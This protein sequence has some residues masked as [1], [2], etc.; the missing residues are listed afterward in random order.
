MSDSST[1]RQLGENMH[2]EHTWSNND[3]KEEILQIFFQLTRSNSKD[4]MERL[5]DRFMT[6]I[7]KITDISNNALYNTLI[8][9]AAHTRDLE[10]GKGEYRLA[11]YLFNSFDRVGHKETAQQL[12][13]WSVTNLPVEQIQQYTNCTNT[14]SEHPLGS[15]KDIKYLWSQFEWS[16]ETSQFMIKLINNQLRKDLVLVQKG[17]PPEGL[18]GKWIPRESSQFKKMFRVLALDYFSDY[19]NTT[20]ES[21]NKRYISTQTRITAAKRK[22]YTDY[23]K[24]ISKL[25]NVLNTVQINQC[26][27]TWSNIDYDK[28]VTSIT[29]S[30]QGRAFRNKNSH[31]HCNKNPD[32]IQAASQFESWLAS[33]VSQGKTIKGTRVGINELVSQ[34]YNCDIQDHSMIS[35]INLQWEDGGK[36][37]NN[38]HNMIAMLDTSLS[39]EGAQMDAGIGLSLRVADKSCIGRRV[40]TFASTPTWHN[41]TNNQDKP[42]FVKDVKTIKNIS[43]WGTSTNFAAA[44]KLILDACVKL[45]LTNKAV[46]EL[47]LVIFSDMQI[48]YQ[49]T[50]SLTNTM[51]EHIESMYKAHGYTVLP[52]ILFWNLRS[53]NGFPVMSNQ[54]NT[55]MLSGFSPLL[56]NTFSNRGM[57]FLY[58]NNPFTQMQYMI[59]NPRYSMLELE[60]KNLCSNNVSSGWGTIYNVHNPITQNHA[61][62][63]N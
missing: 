38:L 40:L 8:K 19:I 53:T 34:A 18:C 43:D 4:V 59:N 44:L 22:A 23:R 13:Y 55:T 50:N 16:H 47:V 27:G 63:W 29:L 30:R 60:W 26:A 42:N 12:I 20:S 14:P 1:L 61:P 57:G 9:I 51:W 49:D 46:S 56:L 17:Q 31:S 62:G 21:C 58:K 11:W 45:S 6:L 35:Q 25:N 54:N 36:Q 7:I 3:I 5:S 24:I 41:L 10:E 33:Q 52:H 28:N 37:I 2:C 48:D 39:T 32:R 15:W